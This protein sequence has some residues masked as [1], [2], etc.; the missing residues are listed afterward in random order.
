[1]KLNQY[2]FKP[3]WQSGDAQ[4]R[5]AA[6]ETDPAPELRDALPQ[7]ARADPDPGVRLAAIRR[8]ADPGLAQKL[9]NDD[10]DR[11]VRSAAQSLWLDLLAGIHPGAPPLDERLRLLRGQ[12]SPELIDHVARHASESELRG[13]AL[14]RV[15]RISLLAERALGDPD[16][17][18]RIAALERI[19][20]EGLLTRIAERARKSDK[21]INQRARA[22]LDALRIA[23]QDDTT[24]NA[25]ARELCARLEQLVR[26]PRIGDDE[27]G[28]ARQWQAI[29]GLVPQDLAVRYA[30]ACA[31]LAASRVRNVVERDAEADE[32]A[33]PP[34][35]SSGGVV[36]Q[37]Q[38]AAAPANDD[39]AA[40]AQADALVAQARFSASLAAAA[41][42]AMREREQRQALR[43]E[44]DEALDQFEQA[45]DHGKAA[46]A[47]AA[48]ARMVAMRKR[49]DDGLPR[50]SI[51]R[52][53]AAE[54]RHDRISQWQRWGDNQRRQQICE[55]MRALPGAGLHPDA[56]ANKVRD[57]RAEWARLDQMEG[58]SGPRG[59]HRLSQRFGA[60]CRHALEPARPYFE[61]R[62]AVR[63]SHAQ[64]I[65]T[66]LS[67]IAGVP[68]DCEDWRAQAKLRQQAAIALQNLDQVD[69]RERKDLARDIKDALD[70][71]DARLHAHYAE[72]ER[73]KADL[74]AEAVGLATGDGRRVAAAARVLQQRWQA[75]G[76]GRRNRDQSQ[77]K[78]FRGALDAAFARLDTERNEIAARAVAAREEADARTAAM[79]DEAVAV[80]LGLE[81]LAS[82]PVSAS[83]AQIAALES[84]WKALDLRDAAFTRRFG[85]AQAALREAAA[86]QARLARR[87]R[88]D[89]WLVRYR[90]CREAEAGSRDPGA[91][92]ERWKGTADSVAASV[93]GERFESALGGDARSPDDSDP[94]SARDLLVRMEAFAGVASPAEDRQ[95]RLDQQVERLSAHL[96]GDERTEPARQLEQMLEAWSRLR[97]PSGQP[98]LQERF[99]QAFEKALEI[100][101]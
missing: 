74:I 83:R 23:R 9:A 35:P 33:M 24:V 19:D 21:Q 95:R 54:Q 57:A 47:H 8:L 58:A 97:F 38:A 42:A 73:V 92:R 99:E 98:E 64:G 51:R 22:R 78:A 16:P 70:R 45:L 52:M 93:L 32:V 63:Q 71:L 39:G 36:A 65:A 3:R 41:A 6:V 69:P 68:A 37:A 53:A 15:E 84:R 25:R 85:N 89:A 82:A 66:L 91:L 1:M 4:V 26:A 46:E 72:V 27:S 96:R 34:A 94:G 49:C 88:F 12:D 62:Q 67:R 40:D 55:E 100:L 17:A 87:A 79:R 30:A 61:K 11:G 28:I 2:L 10:P 14:A 86:Q 77:W 43:G 29:A 90:L 101:D 31:L 5:R 81:A 18:L 44:F 20:D 56:V 7:L 50:S 13:A 75:A 48:H 59:V 60:L 76:N 80:C